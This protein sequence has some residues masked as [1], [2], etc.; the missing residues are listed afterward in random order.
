MKNF[1]ICLSTYFEF[2]SK[3]H[4]TK[5]ILRIKPIK[6]WKNKT[7]IM[8]TLNLLFNVYSNTERL[9]V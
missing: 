6:G 3:V 9:A 5:E 7:V 2:K 8:L 1:I 4:F